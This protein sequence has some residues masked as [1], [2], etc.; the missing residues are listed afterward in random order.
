MQHATI[1]ITMFPIIDWNLYKRKNQNSFQPE[2]KQHVLYHIYSSNRCLERQGIICHNKSTD[3][4][5]LVDVQ[6]GAAREVPQSHGQL[7]LGRH[8]TVDVNARPT[9]C[10]P[11]KRR[12]NAA[13]HTIERVQA[14]PV[15][16]QELSRRQRRYPILPHHPLAIAGVREVSRARN[17]E[18]SIAAQPGSKSSLVPGLLALPGPTRQLN[19][20]DLAA[21]WSPY[22]GAS[23]G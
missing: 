5:H 12:T 17:E 8:R 13:K 11:K 16:A 3:T 22:F 1:V 20:R 10:L 2:L 19:H 7:K 18:M 9:R 15:S 14:H 6:V 4:V 21:I 23:R